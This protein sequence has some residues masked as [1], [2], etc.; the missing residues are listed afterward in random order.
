[1]SYDAERD[2]DHDEIDVNEVEL[3]DDGEDGA[4]VD[5]EPE[6]EPEHDEPEPEYEGQDIEMVPC[7]YCGEPHPVGAWRCRAC[8]GFLP[9][10]E[11]TIHKEH[12]FFLFC[13][14][15]MFIGT[16]LVWEPLTWVSGASSILGGFLLIT[17]A[18]AAFASVIN[19]FHRKMIVWPHLTAMV[20][21][22]WAGW[23]RVIQLI[24][25]AGLQKPAEGAPFG[26]W[27]IFIDS[28][29]H[30][31]GPGLYIVVIVS[32]ML[33]IFMVVSIFVAGKRDAE[34]KKAMRTAD[35]GAR[36]RR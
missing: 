14:L 31:F 15:S 4:P 12:F 18:Y 16:F 9:I 1:M 13:S 30:V 20:L 11:G 21:G 6:P 35:R 33:L 2:E 5:V 36:R 32:T 34:R 8:G 25:N 24:G 23:Q 19:I 7:A 22:L 17:S 29:F 27:K 3:V 10:I 28:I 26:E